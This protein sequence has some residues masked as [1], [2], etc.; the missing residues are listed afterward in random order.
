MRKPEG[1]GEP[2]LVNFPI[3]LDDVLLLLEKI[4]AAGATPENMCMCM[5]GTDTFKI[6]VLKKMPVFLVDMKKCTES[7]P[8]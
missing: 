5:A 2:L 3:F 8:K 4:R 1:L 6:L 7:L